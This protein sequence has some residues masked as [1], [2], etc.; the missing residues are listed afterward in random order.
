[1]TYAPISAG[2]HCNLLLVRLRCWRF[3]RFLISV[4]N[5]SILLSCVECREKGREGENE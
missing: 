1:M 5:F 3:F 2:R 4:G